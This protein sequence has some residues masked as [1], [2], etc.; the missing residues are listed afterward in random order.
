MDDNIVSSINVFNIINNK[1]T[2]C[3]LMNGQDNTIEM[4]LKKCGGI[5]NLVKYAII[6]QHG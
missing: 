2:L 1:E 6:K 5:M 3:G 4:K